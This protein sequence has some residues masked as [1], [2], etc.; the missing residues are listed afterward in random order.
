MYKINSDVCAHCRACI[1]NCPAGAIIEKD[2]F[3]IDQDACAQCG[4]CV[5]NCPCGAIENID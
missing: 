2:E 3:V 5:D 1:D 4:A